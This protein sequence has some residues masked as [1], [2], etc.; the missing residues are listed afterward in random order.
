MLRGEGLRMERERQRT[1]VP[2]F[3]FLS[4]TDN[5]SHYAGD[6]C[7]PRT[8]EETRHRKNGP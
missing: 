2:W 1:Q 8:T 6:L 7:L 3:G 4:H 5:F